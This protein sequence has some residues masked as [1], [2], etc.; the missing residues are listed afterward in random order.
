[1]QSMTVVFNSQSHVPGLGYAI[2]GQEKFTGSEVYFY[3]A[4]E[5]IPTLKLFSPR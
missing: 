1:M 3:S 4:K 2:D 5:F